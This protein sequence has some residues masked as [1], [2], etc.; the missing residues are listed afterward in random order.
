[1]ILLSGSGGN[2]IVLFCVDFSGHILPGDLDILVLLCGD[3]A[4][5][6]DLL[7]HCVGED[8]L[9]LYREDFS[10]L[11][12]GGGVGELL[13]LCGDDV[14]ALPGDVGV[15]LAGVGGLF[16]LYLVILAS[17][18]SE[19]ITEYGSTLAL[20]MDSIRSDNPFESP[21]LKL[22]LPEATGRVL[23]PSL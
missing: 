18:S 17:K 9:L 19:L 5:L 7:L 16:W 22:S 13:L 15:V 6:L 8:D 4:I 21:T 11:L 10:T 2:D 14:S 12:P 23:S 20:D 3:R 1:M